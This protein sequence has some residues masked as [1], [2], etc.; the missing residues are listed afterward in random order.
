MNALP[1]ETIRQLRGPILRSVSR[2]FYLSIR[3]LPL[4]LRDPIALAYLLARATDTIADTTAADGAIRRDE[5]AKL[6]GW[7]QGN[8]T[9]GRVASLDSFAALQKNEAERVLIRAVPDCLA[10]LNSLDRDD[11]SEIRDVLLTIN[12]GQTLD[13]ARFAGPLTAHGG[14]QT[15]ADLDRY[16]YLVAGSVGEFWTRVCGRKLPGFA[17]RGSK[18]MIELGTEYGKGLQLVNILRDIGA[19]M[20]AGRCYLPAEELERAHASAADLARDGS[21]ALPVFGAWLERAERNLDAGLVYSCAIRPFRLR[22][23]TALPALIGA[24]TLALLQQAGAAV[25]E[26]KVKVPRAEVRAIIM[27]ATIALA[28]PPALRRQFERYRK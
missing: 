12:E 14:I 11:R 19:D 21:G 6:A 15:A 13:V 8:T 3:L 28:S 20:R 4:K 26:R 23:A 10:W 16:T 18:E 7:I 5:L 24:R 1:K 2:S 17:E 25:F 9:A 27:N 22:L